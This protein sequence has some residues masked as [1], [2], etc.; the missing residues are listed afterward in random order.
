LLL[1]SAKMALLLT[2]ILCELALS[3]GRKYKQYN[4]RAKLLN[5]VCSVSNSSS[6]TG[7][8]LLF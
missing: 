6:F 7:V 3:C 2:T 5:G 8:N 1:M 4:T